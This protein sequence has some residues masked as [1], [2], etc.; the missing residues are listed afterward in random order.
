VLTD[1]CCAEI[2]YCVHDGTADRCVGGLFR[3]WMTFGV[4]L[5]LFEGFLDIMVFPMYKRVASWMLSSLPQGTESSLPADKM[6][7]EL[8]C[9]EADN[10]P[11]FNIPKSATQC[12][13]QGPM[14][15]TPH[16]LSAT[17][18]L[19]IQCSWTSRYVDKHVIAPTLHLPR[20]TALVF[21]CPTRFL[22][23]YPSFFL[24]GGAGLELMLPTQPFL[25]LA[26]DT[27]PGIDILDLSKQREPRYS[28]VS[29][30]QCGQLGID[31]PD[32][33]DLLYRPRL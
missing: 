10:A 18:P 8:L 7:L 22:A 27:R 25:P 11:P 30:V 28:T 20:H 13:L 9:H 24:A 15:P 3:S 16:E 33:R 6:Y 19:G 2:F 17:T 5:L 4:F 14:E 21:T 29:S 1:G 26:Q 12:C 23:K 32:Q 31:K